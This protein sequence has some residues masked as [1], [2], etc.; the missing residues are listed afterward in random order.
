MTRTAAAL[1]PAAADVLRA[2]TADDHSVTLPPGQL[3]RPVYVE[4]NKV[5]TRIAGGG[6]WNRKAKAHLFTDDPRPELAA[7][8]GSVN[9]DSDDEIVMPVDSD[10]L[11]SFWATPRPVAEWM[12]SLAFTGRPLGEPGLILEPSA[13]DGALGLVIRER[14]PDADLVCVEIDERRAAKCRALGFSTLTMDFR[15]YIEPAADGAA[16]FFDTVVMNP[17]F[18]EEGNPTAWVD[19]ITLALDL[20]VPGGRLVSVVPGSWAFREHRKIDALRERVYG[21]GQG[22]TEW[23]PE[24]AFAVSGTGVHT[25][26]LVVDVPQ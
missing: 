20:L 19:H 21:T 12:C 2:A 4:V 1:S 25:G 6:R 18:T 13:G 9:P 15:D 22:R 23:L 5:L 16:P 8:L 14:A 24:E 3:D 17:P 7:L 11:L 26:L 10:K